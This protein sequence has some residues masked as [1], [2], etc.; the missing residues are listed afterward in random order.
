MGWTE[1]VRGLIDFSIRPIEILHVHENI[2][3]GHEVNFRATRQFS[4]DLYDFV[5]EIDGVLQFK[6]CSCLS[7][8]ISCR[9]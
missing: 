7:K 2:A 3:F 4:T 5:S 9:Y 6:E 8:L 1:F